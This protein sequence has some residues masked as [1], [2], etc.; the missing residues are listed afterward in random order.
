MTTILMIG[1]R[2]ARSKECCKLYS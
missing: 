1:K 2:K